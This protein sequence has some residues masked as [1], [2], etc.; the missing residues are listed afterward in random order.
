MPDGSIMI[1]RFNPATGPDGQLMAFNGPMPGFN[2]ERLLPGRRLALAIPDTSH[3][4]LLDRTQNS[5]AAIAR[6]RIFVPPPSGG[7][8]N[9]PP[10]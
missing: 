10:Y 9:G 2:E 1:A 5:P 6:T 4:D 3:F 7:E 8:S